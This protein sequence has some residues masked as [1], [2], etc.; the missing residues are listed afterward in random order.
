MS[1]LF[2]TLI[3]LAVGGLGIALGGIVAFG[4]GRY[5]ERISGMILACAAGM[6]F[7]LL[8]FELLPESINAG[9]LIA[10][11]IGIIVGTF[12]IVRLEQF[13]HKVVIITDNPR[14]SM[15]IRSGVLLALGVAIHNLPVGFAL[16]TGLIN[17]DK[18]GLDLA[19]TMLLHNFPEGFAIALPLALSGLSPI[20]IPIIAGIVALPA[21]F[22][23]LLGSS[24][25]IINSVLLAIFF[26]IAIGT[27]FLVTWHEI[28]GHAIK[29][30]R[31]VHLVTSIFTG[32]ILGALFVQF[33][34]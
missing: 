29:N 20:S 23:A 1:Q 32:F 8:L 12:L 30:T 16:G 21:G 24:L 15:F 33:V 10:T 25:G 11:G 13:F 26:G 5:F 4:L 34:L 9:G 7:A 19:T 14:K 22:G 28:L 17:N 27:I 3:G 6:I 31:R 18:I 2:P